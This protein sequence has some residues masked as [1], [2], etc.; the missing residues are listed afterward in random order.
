MSKV[1]G[2]YHGD[3]WEGLSLQGDL[4]FKKETAIEFAL[5]LI[6]EKNIQNRKMREFEL[7]EELSDSGESMF[8]DF[9]EVEENKWD[10][11]G[12]E[13]RIYEHSVI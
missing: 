12:Y 2:V 3:S 6:E 1:Y 13:I 11:G 8:P 10:A 7:E 4:Y 9:Q 5:K